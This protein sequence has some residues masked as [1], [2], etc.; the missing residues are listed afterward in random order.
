MKTKKEKEQRIGKHQGISR[1]MALSSGR[2]I[3]LFLM[4]G[5]IGLDQEVL[6]MSRVGSGRVES[7]GFH[8]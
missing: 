4:A 6:K 2:I 3:F 1:V 8:V 5:R 7:R